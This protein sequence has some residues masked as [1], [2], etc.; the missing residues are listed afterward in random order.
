[1]VIV[2]VYSWARL[3]FASLPWKHTWCLLVPWKLVLREETLTLRLCK[4]VVRKQTINHLPKNPLW[5]LS[6]CL[7]IHMLFKWTLPVLADSIPFKSQR[8]STKIPNTSFEKPAFELLIRVVQERTKHIVFY[9]CLDCPQEVENEFLLLKTPSTSGT[10]SRGPWAEPELYF[11]K[12]APVHIAHVCACQV[13]LSFTFF[14]TCW[15]FEWLEL[16]QGSPSLSFGVCL[17][18]PHTAASFEIKGK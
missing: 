15:N 12:Q 11:F 7:S 9:Y 14:F 2:V 6:L 1:M 4:N 10:D 8:L 13:L 5:F 3:L 16:W 17:F 18:H